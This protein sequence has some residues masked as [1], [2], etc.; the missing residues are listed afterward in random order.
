MLSGEPS[1][2]GGAE[3]STAQASGEACRVGRSKAFFE[4]PLDELGHTRSTPPLTFDPR[5]TW[6]ASKRALKLFERPSGEAR[7]A[8]ADKPD[9]HTGFS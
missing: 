1:I 8:C 5:G 7:L 9:P 4:A 2:A 3:T 6:W